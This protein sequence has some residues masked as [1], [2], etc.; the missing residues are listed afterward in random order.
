MPSDRLPLELVLEVL[1]WV[2]EDRLHTRRSPVVELAMT[3]RR[4]YWSLHPVL[5]RIMVITDKNHEALVTLARDAQNHHIFATVRRLHIMRRLGVD[6]L[7]PLSLFTGRGLHIDAHI[8]VVLSFVAAHGSR[9]TSVRTANTRLHPGCLPRSLTHLAVDVPGFDLPTGDWLRDV[10]DQLPGVTHIGFEFMYEE[11]LVNLSADDTLAALFRV[12][13]ER[14]QTVEL[15]ARFV[16]P[17]MRF[18]CSRILSLW[19][20]IN[21]PRYALRFST[22]SMQRRYDQD[23]YFW[24]ESWSGNDVWSGPREK[25]A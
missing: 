4:V 15:S 19:D 6:E 7:P 18:I 20:N 22:D 2:A 17:W 23:R 25:P 14:T 3:S 21:D 5:Y 8:D 13:L 12:A 10:L 11:T 1:R 16:G 9:I 24:Q